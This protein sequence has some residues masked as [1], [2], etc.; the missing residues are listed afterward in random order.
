MQYIDEV[1]DQY[2]PIVT[3]PIMNNVL[4]RQPPH[5]R[6]IIDP[7][8]ALSLELATMVANGR[9]E[10][11]EASVLKRNG[12]NLSSDDATDCETI[13]DD[14]DDDSEDEDDSEYDSEEE[15]DSEDDDVEMIHE[16]SDILYK[17]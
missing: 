2:W 8:N 17:Q 6:P 5:T 3:S 10:P 7:M 15:E 11:H 4:V 1:K 16:M 14:S 12:T 9:L 13:D